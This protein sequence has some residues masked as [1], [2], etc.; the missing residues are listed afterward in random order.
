[1]SIKST[2]IFTSLFIILSSYNAI[3]R[4]DY[5]P[6][7]ITEEDG[8]EAAQSMKSMRP[9][10]DLDHAMVPFSEFE[11]ASQIKKFTLMTEKALD[12]QEIPGL[13]RTSFLANELQ[14]EIISYQLGMKVGFIPSQTA[15]AE[16][17]RDSLKKESWIE[18]IEKDLEKLAPYYRGYDDML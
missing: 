9:L 6:S 11:S 1:M 15:T 5:L 16:E 13:Q 3:V 2:L 17:T 14:D 18:A 7:S 4:A 10:L 12:K 8:I